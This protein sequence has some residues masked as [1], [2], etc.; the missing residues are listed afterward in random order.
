M[1]PDCRERFRPSVLYITRFAN[2]FANHPPGT[3]FSKLPAMKFAYVPLVQM[4]RELHGI[5]RGMNRFRQYLRSMLNEDGTD[6]ALPPLVIMNP[7]G[8]DH[9]TAMLD[10]LLALDA[11]G[12]AARALSEFSPDLVDV[13]GDVKVSLVVA[14]DAM[15]GAT[16]RYAYEYDLRFG[17]EG[18]RSRTGRQHPKQCWVAAVLWSSEAATLQATREAVLTAVYRFAYVHQHGAARTLREMLA[19]EGNVMAMA[20]CTQP[21]LDDE[22][23]G[24]TR[25]VLAPLLDDDGMRIAI[26]CL[27]G[28][29]AAATLGFTPRGLSPWAGLALAL[30]DSRGDASARRATSRSSCDS[31]A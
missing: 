5:P 14:D 25:E 20:G 15:G 28:D 13:P 23:L 16:N 17:P 3:S 9:M 24:Y 12:V 1:C 7:M 30:H 11:D 19:Q 6:V 8:K 10:T 29:S 31:S 27:F 22:D 18:L 26:E 2:A 4:Q 21:I